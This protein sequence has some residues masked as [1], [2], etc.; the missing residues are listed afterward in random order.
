M[1]RWKTKLTAIFMT[2]I[3][4]T[5]IFAPATMLPSAEASGLTVVSSLSQL[6]TVGETTR[7]N[8][9]L[10]EDPDVK[11]DARFFSDNSGVAGGLAPSHPFLTAVA[12]GK[13]T[14]TAQYSDPVTK[15]YYTGTLTIN[16][17][18]APPQAKGRIFFI[19][20]SANCDIGETVSF[21]ARYIDPVTGA[22]TDITSLATWS[23]SDVKVADLTRP[24]HFKATL[25][26]EVVLRATHLGV[27]AS[28]TLTVNS[29]PKGPFIRVI[30]ESFHAGIGDTVQFRVMYYP[31]WAANPDDVT[32]ECN[33][34][35]GKPIAVTDGKGSY[36]AAAVGETFITVAYTNQRRT[37][38]WDRVPY[39]VSY[40]APQ[41]EAAEPS[42]PEFS[43]F[44]INARDYQIDYRA[45]KAPV[46]TY[47]LAGRA[48]LPQR[49]LAEAMGVEV[50][51]D[52][53]SQSATFSDPTTGSI[54]VMRKG[55]SSYTLN[56][57]KLQMD[58]T[59]CIVD[60]S[61]TCPA[62]FLAD[63]FGYRINLNRPNNLVIIFR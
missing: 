20:A 31:D 18:P 24:G 21:A 25:P 26:G 34:V 40:V 59:P 54:V 3:L 6:I 61:L 9:F 27:S 51:W 52:A 55:S 41:P 36:T 16:V 48:Y 56:G 7:L 1:K 45:L 32:K 22:N 63:A 23:S 53:A 35:L 2:A 44:T 43:T 8:A 46:A 37:I 57:V 42:R 38:L 28:T 29:P 62:R 4:S 39:Q 50:L 33:W 15:N 30:P 49:A 10:S 47:L 5:I 11:V 19:P 13:V 17:L 12:P 58:A 60:G 14:V